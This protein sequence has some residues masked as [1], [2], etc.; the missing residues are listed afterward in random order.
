MSKYV[1]GEHQGCTREYAKGHLFLVVVRLVGTNVPTSRT[2]RRVE[3][4]SVQ[5]TANGLFINEKSNIWLPIVNFA[6]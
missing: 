5:I 1:A 4:T 6:G 3:N 2:S